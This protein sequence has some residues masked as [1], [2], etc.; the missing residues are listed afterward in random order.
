MIDVTLENFETEVIAASMTQPVLVDFWAPWCGPCKVI[1]PLL[2]K[3]E[4]EYAGRFKLVKIDSDQ[5]Q[6]L[7]AAFGIRSIPTCILLMN[8]QPVDGFMG[9]VP[10]GKLRE[11]LD[12]HV[13]PA[14]EAPEEL[15]EEEAPADAQG[16]LEKLQHAVATNP[17]DDDARFEYVKA[18]LM[19]GRSDDAKVAFAPVI[20]K[21]PGIRRLESLQR[22]L[23]A[24][25]FA[26]QQGDAAKAVA[27]FEARVT[28]NKRDFEARFAKAQVLAG[29]RRWTDAMDELL[30]ILMRDKS[31]NEDAARKTYIAILDVIEPAKPKVAEG[32]IP[33]DDPV[34]A[35]YRRRLSSVVLS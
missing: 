33:P 9:A 6:Q 10:E 35:T 15:L 30:E 8:G 28:A 16:Q 32:Q 2:E 11:F 23:D 13:P 31:W 19:A 1:G 7:A 20:G 3:L 34:V 25:D 14:D 26:A 12:K 18:L 5:E 22:V 27:G 24:T 4:A 21:A 17:S 29:Q